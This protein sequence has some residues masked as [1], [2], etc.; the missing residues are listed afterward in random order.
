MFVVDAYWAPHIAF[1]DIVL[2]ACTSYE[3]SHQIFAR[4]VKEGTWLGIYNKDCRTAGRISFGL[5]DLSGSGGK[6]GL[7]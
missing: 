1:A 4:N 7:R 2:P 5:A 6:N 3:H